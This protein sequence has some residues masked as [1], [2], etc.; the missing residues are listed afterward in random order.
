M[1][2]ESILL[3]AIAEV[4][5]ALATRR[6]I[7]MLSAGYPDILLNRSQ[8]DGI[9]DA[10]WIDDIPARLDSATIAQ[11]HGLTDRLP[12]VVDSAA[13]FARL[14]IQL[15]VID[16]I[17]QR[18]GE[19][20]A[21]LNYP[22]DISTIG[23]HDIVLDSGTPEHVFHVGQALLT[24]ASLVNEGGYIIQ[25]LPLNG[26]NHGFYNINPTLLVDL[27]SAEH[28]FQLLHLHGYHSLMTQPKVFEVV[29]HGRFRGVPE[30]S[31]LV[32][33]AKRI[34][35]VPIKPFIQRKYRP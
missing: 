35:S 19:I 7:R 9:L 8:I 16:A 18:G 31:I 14:G 25:A 5:K 2:I 4:R 3:G 23:T 30:N 10:D 27:Y 22:V 13:L 29:H 28:G 32:A 15:S 6:N 26:F 21:D 17:P 11:W 33:I 1:A 34:R 20:I 12:E 24:L